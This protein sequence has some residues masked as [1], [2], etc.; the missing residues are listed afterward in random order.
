MTTELKIRLGSFRAEH[1][2]MRAKTEVDIEMFL[3][4]LK[5]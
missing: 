3:C 2:P 4:K 1:F 5:K